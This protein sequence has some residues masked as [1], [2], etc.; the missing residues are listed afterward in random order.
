[1]T[2]NVVEEFGLLAGPGGAPG[3]RFG[4]HFPGR[5]DDGG[6]RKVS[7]EFGEAALFPH[8]RRWRTRGG[9]SSVR[10]RVSG[11]GFLNRWSVAG[12]GRFL[13]KG[14]EN[15]LQLAGIELLGGTAEE[16]ARQGVDLEP[17]HVFFL[18][19]PLHFLL[20]PLEVRG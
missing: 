17:Q 11:G 16:F 6:R 1:M 19:E 14:V 20:K 4:F 2:G 12:G 3:S 5:Q 15:E 8:R 13:G 18:P 10:T 7:D 9:R